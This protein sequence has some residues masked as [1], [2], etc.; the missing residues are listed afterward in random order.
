MAMARPNSSTESLAQTGLLAAL[1]VVLYV[2]GASLP[3]VGRYLKLLCPGVIGIVSQ[4]WGMR[5]GVLLA[6]VSSVIIGMSVGFRELFIF[7]L[8]LAPVGLVLPSLRRKGLRLEY[9]LYW[10][11]YTLCFTALVLILSR[12][13]GLS[14]TEFIEQMSLV[15]YGLYGRVYQG[16]NISAEGFAAVVSRWIWAL[17]P[18]LSLAYGA[19][20]T[21]I[22]RIV[23]AKGSALLPQE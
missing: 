3:G 20:L 14:L 18:V 7:A 1:C 10:L 19:M 16:M 17:L 4:R 8:L 6:V 12:L 23:L 15:H 22:N 13:M 11:G 5:Q 9:I 2:L 21:L